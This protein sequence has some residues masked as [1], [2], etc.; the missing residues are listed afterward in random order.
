MNQTTQNHEIQVDTTVQTVTVGT[1]AKVMEM[2]LWLL[3]ILPG[4]I[5]QMCK[6]SAENYFNALEQKIRNQASEIDN[7]LEQRVMVLQNCARLLDRAVALDQST[8][9][10]ITEL[11]YCGGM[12]DAARN[13]LSVELDNQWNNVHMMVERYPDLRAHDA[14]QEAM[15][16]NLML[17]KEITAARTLYNDTV[18]AWNSAIFQWP[19]K[20]VV[21]AKHRYTTRIPFVA[22]KEVKQRATEVFF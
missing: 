22:S 17:Q 7:Y 2:V 3:F 8:F 11:K 16:Q 5:F 1:E 21:A 13:Q 4:L 18:Y 14:I 19:A 6:L 12:D 10:K 15:R 20:R 9:T